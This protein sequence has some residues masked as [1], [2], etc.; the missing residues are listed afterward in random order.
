MTYRFCLSAEA[1][2]IAYE[3]IIF[4]L[5]SYFFSYIEKKKNC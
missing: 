3:E 5:Y 2:L 4:A 1:K